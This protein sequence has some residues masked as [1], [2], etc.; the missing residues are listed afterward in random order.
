MTEATE[1]M[2]TV[3]LDKVKQCFSLNRKAA[4][5]GAGV[6]LAYGWGGNL[7]SGYVDPHNGPPRMKTDI[8]IQI[9]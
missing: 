8:E 2:D 7:S 1:L 5:P 4:K 6:R 9:S 3:R